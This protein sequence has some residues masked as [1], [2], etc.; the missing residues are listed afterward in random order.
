MRMAEKKKAEVVP[1]EDENDEDEN[2]SEI[3]AVRLDAVKA[4]NGR[5]DQIEDE[6]AAAR[7]HPDQIL[8]RLARL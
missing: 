8:T 1:E 7:T 6:L 4:L 2:F 3:F 5:F